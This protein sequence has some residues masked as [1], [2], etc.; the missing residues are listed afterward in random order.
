MTS[1]EVSVR[2]NSPAVVA[3]LGDLARRQLPFATAVALTRVAVD[4]QAYAR[5]RLALYFPGP[6]KQGRSISPRLAK[7]IRVQAARKTDWPHPR[8]LLGL[9][10]EFMAMH[11][12]GGVKR[13]EGGASRVAVPTRLVVRTSQGKVPAGLKPRT[14]R[15]RKS[16]FV[17]ATS[18]PAQI[19]QRLGKNRRAAL[20]NLGD[21]ATWF[22]LV[23]SARIVRSWPLDN[24]TREVVSAGY[25]DHFE[26]ELTAAV[27]SARVR[28]GSFTSFEGRSA[29]LVKRRELG[30]ITPYRRAVVDPIAR[31]VSRIGA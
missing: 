2:T 14:L 25:A 28:A 19:V 4:S 8:A 12:I 30:R 15:A 10:D 7:G 20:R 21:R 17:T 31:L 23:T 9:L 26:R 18:G 27:R 11:V 1:I 5:N 29:Y 16:V 6:A 3:A 13:P 22:S 24:D